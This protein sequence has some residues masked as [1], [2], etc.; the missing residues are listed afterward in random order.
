MA[1]EKYDWQ[2]DAVPVAQ[3]DLI[4]LVANAALETDDRLIGTIN[5][6]SVNVAAGSTNVDTAADA[7][8]A[9]W[10]ASTV[11]E[12][13]EITAS[14]GGT[15]IIAMTADT[16]GKPFTLTASTT[17]AGGGASDGQ[18]FTRSASVA[19]DGPKAWTANNFKDLATGA[20][21]VLP[22]AAATQQVF[23]QD[24][25]GDI[26]YNLDQSGIANTLSLFATFKSFTGRI[27][28]P[29]TNIDN[30]AVGM[31][32]D[33]YR[34]RYLKIKAAHARI[35]YG[36]GTGSPRTMIDFG[37]TACK[38]KVYGSGTPDDNYP[39]VRILGTAAANSL[40]CL[41]GSTGIA[42]D[43]GEISTFDEIYVTGDAQLRIGGGVTL[44][45][46]NVADNAQVWINWR[47][48]GLV[49]LYMTGNAKVYL[50]G[51]V[52][53]IGDTALT[54]NEIFLR[55]KAFLYLNCE[56]GSSAD[57]KIGSSATLDTRQGPSKMTGSVVNVFT[58]TNLV[59][60]MGGN[61]NDGLTNIIDPGKRIYFQA[62]LQLDGP[63][64]GFNLDL[65]TPVK[66][67]VGGG[68]LS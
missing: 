31:S 11:P 52:N 3:I 59:T 30:T 13:A 36:P 6:K 51:G 58:V 28:L 35:G 44:G 37:S 61:Q 12:H 14:D 32:Y 19:N 20:R 45:T 48:T 24:K 7:F 1:N 56:S 63:V 39:P 49:N 26:L 8:D 10:D 62:G 23:I 66:L 15:G 47:T 2:G 67:V 33:E 25:S 17:E 5:G 41:G 54:M 27:G 38:V 60:A 4:T 53:M 18:T 43:E 65:G 42:L 64:K 16:P 50:Y 57:M 29:R 46:V 68:S 22:G 55:S 9:A 21:G 34:P 40:E